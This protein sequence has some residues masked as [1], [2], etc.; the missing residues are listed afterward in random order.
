MSETA[1]IGVSACLLGEKVFW[2]GSHKR[3]CYPSDILANH[4]ELFPVCPEVGSGMDVPREQLRQVNSAG[5]THLIGRQ[6]GTDWTTAMNAW[7]DRIMPHLVNAPLDGFILRAQSPSCGLRGIPT[8]SP[9]HTSSRAGQGFFVR[10]LKKHIPLLPMETA[11]RL[12]LP[13]IRRNFIRRVFV[14]HRW[15][16]MLAK[17]ENIGNLVDFHTRHKML[18]RAHDLRGYRE[19]GHLLGQAT[20]SNTEGIFTEYA[21]RLFKS[22]RLQATP[23]KNSDVL[24][25]AMGFFKNQLDTGDKQELIRLITEYKNG[26]ISLLTPV[27][28]LNHYA[29]KYQKPYLTQ[30]YYLNPSPTEL[31]LLYLV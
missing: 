25:H 4:I 6:S 14:S 1:N 8:Y 19:L 23:K 20:Q 7:A 15:H 2:D 27:T 9:D 12:R 16:T 31:Q 29:R 26:T 3:E 24:F 11:D 28:I 22:M 5:G 13:A 17:G 30:Q 18:I 21:T 10:L